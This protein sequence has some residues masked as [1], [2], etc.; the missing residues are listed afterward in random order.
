[1]YDLIDYHIYKLLNKTY[2]LLFG[3]NIRDLLDKS[4][5]MVTCNSTADLLKK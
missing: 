3:V 5:C 1:M 2:V 4:F